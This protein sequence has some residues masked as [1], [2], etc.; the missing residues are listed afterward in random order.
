M[1]KLDNFISKKCSIFNN[2]VIKENT[3]KPIYK[4]VLSILYAY[5][6]LIIL[7]AVY[8]V[9]YA[10][11][12][13]G[14]ILLYIFRFSWGFFLIPMFTILASVLNS[15]IGFNTLFLLVSCIFFLK[16]IHKI[17]TQIKT[18]MIVIIVEL[19]SLIMIPSV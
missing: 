11:R 2:F 5:L 15:H 7:S 19:Y 18:M 6:F 14:D 13:S 17:N 4:I 10:E 9:I 16:L 8:S 3:I 12:F 1:D